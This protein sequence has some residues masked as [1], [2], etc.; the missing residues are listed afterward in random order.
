MLR[1]LLLIVDPTNPRQGVTDAALAWIKDSGAH[2]TAM[3][4]SP[5][6]NWE[7]L[8]DE[9][10][11]GAFRIPRFS[12]RTEAAGVSR[13]MDEALSNIHNQCVRKAVNVRTLKVESNNL[14]VVLNQALAHDMIFVDLNTVLDSPR[15]GTLSR[16]YSRRG[17]R[18]VM[19]VGEQDPEDAPGRTLVCLD[20]QRQSW[21][22]LQLFLQLTPVNR[23]E[24]LTLMTLGQTPD[25]M[26]TCQKRVKLASSLVRSYGIPFKEVVQE[27]TP[28]RVIP[29]VAR[30]IGAQTI[31]LGPHTRA[32]MKRLFMGSVTEKM[33]KQKHYSLF[34]Y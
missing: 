34:L 4:V 1:S 33:L 14:D 10:G 26:E 20:A 30:G 19:L 15:L 13:Q 32:Q 9:S 24:S 23:I 6:G 27:G 2:L 25:Q 29:E 5:V 8:P 16:G 31:V 12:G 28:L 11:S 3:A 22:A 17:V 18:P 21:R 7:G